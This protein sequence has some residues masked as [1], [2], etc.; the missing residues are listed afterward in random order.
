MGNSTIEKLQLNSADLGDEV[1]LLLNITRKPIWDWPSRLAW[2]LGV[3]SSQG[4][5]FNS[6]DINFGGLS[7]YKTMFWL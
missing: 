4:L 7:P 6:P 2:D 3:C 1:S 5:R